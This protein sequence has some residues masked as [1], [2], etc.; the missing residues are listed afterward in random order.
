MKYKAGDK[1]KIKSWKEMEKEFGPSDSGIINCKL[2]FTGTMERELN[3]KFPDRILTIEDINEA[4]NY[5]GMEK[6][7]IEKI[8]TQWTDDMIKCKIE[9]P[10]I[11]NRF[12]IL[13]IR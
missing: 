2:S 4:G 1:V 10:K 5:Y 7:G 6:Y 11:N 3:K 12:E 9:E 13:D 8:S